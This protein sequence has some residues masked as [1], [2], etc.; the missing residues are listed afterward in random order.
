MAMS[1][2]DYNLLRP[3]RALLDERSVTRAAERLHVSQPTMSIALARL[4][5]HFDDPILVRKGNRHEL[6]PLAVRLAA[7]LPVAIGEVE[8]VFQLQSRFDPST[9]DRSFVIAGV[10]YTVARIGPVLAK[11]VRLEA[12]RVTFEFPAADSNLVNGAPDTLQRVDGLF[13]PHGFLADQ[14][15]LDLVTDP[16]AVIVSADSTVGEHPSVDELRRLPWVHTLTLKEGM[17]PARRQ[18]QSRGIDVSVAAVTP[19]FHVIPSLI[20]GTDRVALLPSPL[21]RRVA[22]EGNVRIVESPFKLDPIREAFWWHRSRQHDVEHVWLRSILERI[23]SE[24]SS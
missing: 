17:T 2:I 4:R 18:L 24:L 11:L 14:P 22:R 8:R 6:S 12:P 13:L 10:D 5:A 19:H 9:S 23:G 21:A 20:E 7:A 16:W 3:L 1:S 15:H